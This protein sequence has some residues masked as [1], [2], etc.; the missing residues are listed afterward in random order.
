MENFPA[1]KQ[2]D[3]RKASSVALT[4][5][6]PPEAQAPTH[7]QVLRCHPEAPP[8][9]RALHDQQNAEGHSKVSEDPFESPLRSIICIGLLCLHSLCALQKGQQGHHQSLPA[10]ST[11]CNGVHALSALLGL[12]L[13][14]RL[15]LQSN[16]Q[17]QPE[18]VE[19]LHCQS[20]R[21]EVR[22]VVLAWHCVQA[23]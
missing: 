11:E 4:L 16:A 13:I 22:S 1:F 5:G 10:E 3:L 14:G 8:Q 20:L 7:S 17:L 2:V 6:G 18:H 9:C 12:L 23:E 21:P 15:L 19:P